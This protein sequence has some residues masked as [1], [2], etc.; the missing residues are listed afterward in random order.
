MQASAGEVATLPSKQHR[1]CCCRLLPRQL[2]RRRVQQA[3][4]HAIR[5]TA[6]HQQH[7]LFLRW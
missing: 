1:A 3:D 4:L 7:L 2:Q 5:S 6:L